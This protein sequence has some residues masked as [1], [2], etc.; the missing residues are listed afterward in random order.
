MSTSPRDPLPGV[1]EALAREL[2]W[3]QEAASVSSMDMAELR[4][5]LHDFTAR[6]RGDERQNVPR[7]EPNLASPSTWRRRLKVL[8]FRAFRPMSRRYDRLV[9]DL[10]ELA[11]GLADRLARLEA[12][13]EHLRGDARRG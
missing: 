9:G 6:M 3:A 7:S 1:S 10:G 5:A 12:E 4:D 11:A 8:Q 13:V 2:F